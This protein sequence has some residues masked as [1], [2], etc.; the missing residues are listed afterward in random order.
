MKEQNGIQIFD[1]A[2][3]RPGLG[4]ELDGVD[5]ANFHFPYGVKVVDVNGKRKLA[6]GTLVDFQESEGKRLGVAPA[7]IKALLNF[8]CNLVGKKSVNCKGGV[9]CSAG[10]VCKAFYNPVYDYWYCQCG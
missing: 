8:P 10:L 7:T 5:L 6:A 4:L 9:G 1:E 2:D 3:E